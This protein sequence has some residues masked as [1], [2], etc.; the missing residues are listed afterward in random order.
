[1]SDDTANRHI[2][3]LED[4]GAT[5]FDIAQFTRMSP[6]TF[7][8]IA[9]SIDGDKLTH[10]GEAIALIPENA[11]KVA[12]AV[13]EIKKAIPVKPAVVKPA[14]P[15]PEDPVEAMSQKCFRL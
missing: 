7:R 14:P 10:N 12:A 11:E 13:A 6:A 5:Y 2:K 8:A 9:P 1:M 15:E 4:Y 3:L